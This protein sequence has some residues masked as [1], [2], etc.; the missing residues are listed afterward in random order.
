MDSAAEVEHL[1]KGDELYSWSDTPG[2]ASSQFAT[3]R[4]ARDARTDG[5]RE[6]DCTEVALECDGRVATVRLTHDHVAM[7][8]LGLMHFR[9]RE[10]LLSY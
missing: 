5:Q 9:I 1:R 2:P 10:R 4:V 8:A 7:V 3:A 6:H